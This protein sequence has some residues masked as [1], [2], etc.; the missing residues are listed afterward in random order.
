MQRH[1]R[2]F[3]DEADFLKSLNSE[4]VTAVGDPPCDV[5]DGDGRSQ[6]PPNGQQKIREQAERCEDHPEDFPFH[7]VIVGARVPQVSRAGGPEQ[8][9]RHACALR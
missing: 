8:H 5:E 1:G 4:P 3:Y 6:A 2:Q 7:G 9:F